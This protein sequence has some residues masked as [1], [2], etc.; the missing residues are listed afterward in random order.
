[1]RRFTAIE[2][3]LGVSLLGCIAAVAI[4]TFVREVHASRFV[5]PTDGL[6]RLGLHAATYAEGHGQFP[7]SVPLTPVTPPHGKKDVDPPSTWDHP[8]WKALDFRASPE[9]VPH[10]YSFAF[11][12]TGGGFVA[13]ARG[14]LDG[15]GILSTFEIRGSVKGDKAQVDPGMYIEAELE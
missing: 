7:A 13:R 1:M 4:P 10:A 15:D 8:T 9:G 6:T 11:D 3:A 2:L 12:A 14:D 5:E